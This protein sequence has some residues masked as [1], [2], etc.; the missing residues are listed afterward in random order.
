MQKNPGLVPGFFVSRLSKNLSRR[1]DRVNRG[2]VLPC[3]HAKSF[4]TTR[5][6]N[7]SNAC[8]YSLVLTRTIGF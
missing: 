5:S 1:M 7:L 6:T 2:E 3:R 8:Q 4:N